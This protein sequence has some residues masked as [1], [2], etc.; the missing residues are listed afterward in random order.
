MEV[1]II[2]TDTEDG[3]IRSQLTW[4]GPEKINIMNATPALLA[5][6]QA[7]DFL[8][9]AGPLAAATLKINQMNYMA[10]HREDASLN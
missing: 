7:C 6:K 2:L 3:H 8:E 9:T 4:D 10:K 5:G 1:R